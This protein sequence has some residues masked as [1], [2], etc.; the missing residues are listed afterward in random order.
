MALSSA[1]LQFAKRHGG[2]LWGKG[3]GGTS[4]GLGVLLE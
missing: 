4:N 1:L 3:G 2:A